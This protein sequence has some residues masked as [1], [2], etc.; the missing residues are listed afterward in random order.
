MGFG[1]YSGFRNRA[2]ETEYIEPRRRYY[3][4]CEGENTEVWYFKRMIDRQREFGI[5]PPIEICLIEK[6]EE[7]KSVSNPERLL[8][9]GRRIK[10]KFLPGHD[11]HRL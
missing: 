6:T 11:S 5:K 2:S 10:K 9:F 7:D 4:I 1:V 3:F 8:E